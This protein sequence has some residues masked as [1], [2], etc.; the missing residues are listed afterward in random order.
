MGEILPGFRLVME[1][2]PPFHY[3]DSPLTFACEAQHARWKKGNQI[4]MDLFS[5]FTTGSLWDLLCLSFPSY[6]NGTG[7]SFSSLYYVQE[8]FGQKVRYV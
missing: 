1:H 8:I 6:I 2:L 3:S 5:R 4:S 7:N